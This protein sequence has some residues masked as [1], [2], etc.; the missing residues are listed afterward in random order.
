MTPEG[1]AEAVDPG[2]RGGKDGRI[3]RHEWCRDLA[4]ALEV[5]GLEPL[6]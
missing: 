5:V 3:V 4:A 1:N 2:I 6:R